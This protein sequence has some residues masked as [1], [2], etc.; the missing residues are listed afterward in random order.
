VVLHQ[1]LQ[2]AALAAAAI[3]D[4]LALLI[5]AV[6]VAVLLSHLHYITMALTAVLE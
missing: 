6:A 2:L 3:P 5:Q 1:L 4:L